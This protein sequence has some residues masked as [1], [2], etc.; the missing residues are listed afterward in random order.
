MSDR[1]Q[2]GDGDANLMPNWCPT[3]ADIDGNSDGSTDS[4]NTTNADRIRRKPCFAL[5]RESSQSD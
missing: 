3:D 4:V 1:D 5:L 2:E